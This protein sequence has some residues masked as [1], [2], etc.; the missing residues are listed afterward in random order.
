[1][2][3][4]ARHEGALYRRL[5]ALADATDDAIADAA[6]RYGPLGPLG[7][8]AIADQPTFLL[9]M[10]Y[11]FRRTVDELPL[12][13]RWIATGGQTSIPGRLAPTAHTLAAIAE[14]DPRVTRGLLDLLDGSTTAFSPEELRGLDE[15]VD[16]HEQALDAALALRAADMDAHRA[17]DDATVRV[18][19]PNEA[20]RYLPLA[21]EWVRKMAPS[22]A[23]SG[24]VAALIQPETLS[25]FAS[26][27]RPYVPGNDFYPEESTTSWRQAGE[28]MAL[29]TA[30]LA[31]ARAASPS[32][33][34]ELIAGLTHRLQHVGFWPFP[35][36]SVVPTFARALWA[37]WVPLVGSRPE[38]RCQWPDCRRMLPGD[39]HGNLRYCTD[40]RR[41]ADRLRAATNR[42]RRTSQESNI[43]G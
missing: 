22:L 20:A 40:H 43:P 15:I 27:V 35:A 39:A 1:V 19:V 13:R 12:L 3:V 10:D 2:K 42:R 7:P 14:A 31:T 32:Q 29:W 4:R 8:L 37:L 34:A 9:A 18:H 36:G 6:S 30:K 26:Q 16:R 33:R 5:A 41:E 23:A 38:R 11:A 17:L 21:A 25:Q 28:E 24:G